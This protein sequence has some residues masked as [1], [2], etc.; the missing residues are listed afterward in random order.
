M[1]L[2]REDEDEVL[3]DSEG[4][5]PQAVQDNCLGGKIE[6]RGCVGMVSSGQEVRYVL[7]VLV[8]R[9]AALFGRERLTAPPPRGDQQQPQELGQADRNQSRTSFG[10]L[11]EVGGGDPGVP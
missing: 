6:A 1:A 5:L 11:P 10:G 2:R 4:H 3:S 8:R 9:L 7:Q